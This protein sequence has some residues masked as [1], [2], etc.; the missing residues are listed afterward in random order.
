MTS[1]SSR[2]PLFTRAAMFSNQEKT[3]SKKVSPKRT[4][5]SVTVTEG[6]KTTIHAT[7]DT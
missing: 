6:E 5:T 4:F 1:L 2:V 7:D 3:P